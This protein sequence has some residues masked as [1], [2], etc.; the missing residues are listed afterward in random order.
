MKRFSQM[1]AAVALMVMPLAIACAQDVAPQ[2]NQTQFSLVSNPKFL[3]CLAQYP[4][5][6]TR[7]PTATVRVLRG[8]LTDS[9]QLTGKWIKPNLQFDL[10]TVKKSNL[11]SDGTADPAFTTFG[12]AWY[13]T[14]VQANSTGNITANIKTILLDQIFGFDADLSNPD[15][16][17]A[18]HVGFWFNNPNDAAACGF[19]TSKPTPFNGEHAAGPVAMISLPNATTDLG[20]LCTNPNLSTSPVSCNP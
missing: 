8:S 14:D 3:S 2:V 15:P 5:D 10:F 19:D 16:I 11:L 13:Q 4:T 12:M 9:L 6:P 20:P 7:P 1:T 18:F 17:N